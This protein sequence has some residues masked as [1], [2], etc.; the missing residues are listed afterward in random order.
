MYPPG[1]V[2]NIIQDAVNA[3]SDFEAAGVRLDVNIA[4]TVFNRSGD[5]QVDQFDDRRVAGFIEQIGCFINPGDQIIGVGV[6]HFFKIVFGGGAAHVVGHIDG[7]H[8]GV[9]R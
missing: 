8:D 3:I 9:L 5:Q 7:R 6:I 4:G 2:Q 1:Q